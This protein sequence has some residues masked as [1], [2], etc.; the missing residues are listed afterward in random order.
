MIRVVDTLSPLHTIYSSV[1]FS[2]HTLLLLVIISA[3]VS[4]AECFSIH[5]AWYSLNYSWDDNHTYTEYV[6]SGRFDYRNCTLAGIAVD[7]TGGIYVTVPRWKSGGPATL[8]RLTLNEVT[9]EHT[10][11]P[12]PSW[13]MQEEGVSGDLQSSQSM[14]IDSQNRMWVIETGKRNFLEPAEYQVPG[15][16]GVWVIDIDTDTVLSTHY[17]PHDVISNSSSFLND[18]VVDDTAGVAYLSDSGDGGGLIVY[19]YLTGESR[20]YVGTSTAND[21]S[22][23]YIIN[24]VYYG[25]DQFTGAANGISL[26]EDSSALLYCALQGTTL[27]RVPTAVLRDFSSTDE[28]ISAMV[29]ALGSKQPS[30]GIRYWDGVLYYG[31]IPESTYYALE[32]SSVSYPDVAADSVPV[33]PDDVNMRWV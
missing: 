6:E 5:A 28:E 30:D 23:E 13:D 29:E 24:G 10:L 12:Y 3:A 9:G 7:R 33:W 15:N 8:N 19:N 18:I 25:T 22:Y 11:T 21:P 32:V 1:S 20:R 2:M 14:F 4:R 31:S 27:Y 16:P 26:T 17:F